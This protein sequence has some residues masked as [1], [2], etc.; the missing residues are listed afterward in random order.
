MNLLIL[1][2][3]TSIASFCLE[4]AYELRIFKDA[5]DAGYRVNTKKLSEFG[6]QLNP[7]ASKITFF[8]MLIPI[9]N[10]M[11][12]FQKIIEYNNIRPMILDQLNIIDAL[13][14]MSE[15]EK[16]EYLK[17]P[18]GLN[19]VIILLKSE[20]RLSQ[21]MV[22]EMNDDNG[23][24]KIYYKIDESSDDITILKAIGSASRLTVEEQKKVVME[25][26]EKFF[27]EVRQKAMPIFL[28][29][30]KDKKEEETTSLSSQKL[31]I[32]EK[33]QELENLKSDLLEEKETVQST[34]TDKGPTL[35]KRRRK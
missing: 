13:E 27:E 19:A 29:Q 14:E 28:K 6:N 24:G 25:E 32:S 15:T 5:A 23:Y 30:L 8:S 21:A 31:S 11:Q 10:I 3:E 35:S 16:T 17:N 4:I 7:N 9:F 18:T 34:K 12:V 1:W 26:W 2:L 22:C 20:A 33:K